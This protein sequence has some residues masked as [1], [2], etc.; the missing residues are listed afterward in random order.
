MVE[1]ERQRSQPGSSTHPPSPVRLILLSFLMLFVE[2]GLIRW[3]GA[4]VV[5][6]SFFTNFVLLASF[7]GVGVG[8]LRARARG[9]TFRHFPLML[10]ALVLFLAVFPVQGGRVAGR[11][12]FVGAFGWPALP[13]WLSL[14]VVFLLAFLI[15]VAIAEGV[16]RTFVRFE[17]LEA[18]RWDILGSM[19]GIAAF[20]GL[21]F[22]EASPLV[23]VVIAAAIFAAVVE[24]RVAQIAPLAGAIV[25]L[26]VLS[27][28]PDTRWSPYYRVTTR[29]VS[30][31]GSVAISVNGR[32]HQ[33]IMPL[34]FMEATQTFR[35]EPYR[36]APDNSLTDVL[37]IGSGS[38]NDVAIALSR[39]AGHVDAVEID[40]LLY[41]LGRDLHPDRPYQDPRVAAHV[42]DGR[43]FLHDTERRYDLVLYAIPD[44]LTVLAGQSSLRLESYLLTREAMQEVRDHL[45]PNG[46]IS[47]YHYYLPVVV[48]RYADALTGV[49]GDPPCLELTA[50]AGPRP[51]TVLTASMRP[52]DLSCD[53]RWSRPRELVAP[54]T[55]DHPFAYL[56]ERGIPGFYQVTL[57]AILLGSLAAVRLAAGPFGQ[58]RPYVDLFFMGAAFLLLETSNVVRFAL[59]FGTTWFVNALV[60][61]GILGSVYLAIEVAR[62]VRFRRPARLYAPLFATLVLAWAVPPESLLDLDFVPR[63]AAAVALGFAP[64]FIAN[65]VF[66]DRFRDVGSS[67][68]AFGT[69]LLGAIAGG[70]LEYGALVVGYRALLI[71]VAALYALA[72]LAGRSH[73]DRTRER[74]LVAQVAARARGA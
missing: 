50:G 66:A 20:S 56:L 60:F 72:L 37:I 9:D 67:A 48:D 35:F 45:K 14:G 47:M 11:L 38:G 42:E 13:K 27:F 10:A 49:F 24:L 17:P 43:S 73:L 36:H 32:P 44:S 19:L 46:V 3:S 15:M 30:D 34:A 41:R 16:G 8:F 31:D 5:Y 6:L 26:G 57:L 25:V 23:W 21:S 74:T 54:V 61:A 12:Q 33:R 1:L 39:G 64:V 68:V 55:D 2:L 69:N 29:A 18:Y 22:L 59:L 51:R 4:Y 58:M 28:A 52:G 70:V 53:E 7:L 62:R 65:L 71:V 40:P 63:F